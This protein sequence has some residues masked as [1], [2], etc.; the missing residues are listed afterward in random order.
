MSI[1]KSD[2]KILFSESGGVCAF[3]KCERR[4]VQ[5]E[6]PDDDAVLLA[7]VAH[8]VAE[9]SDGPRGESP[10]SLAERNKAGNL[11]VL[12]TEHHTIV[13]GQPNTYGVAVLHQMKLD[14]QHRIQRLTS[15][16]RPIAPPRHSSETLL[17]TLLPVTRLPAF[18]F[19]APCDLDDAQDKEVREA[20][21]YPENRW[22]IAPFLIRERTLFAF[23]SLCDPSNPFRGVVDYAKAESVPSKQFWSTPEGQRRFVTLLNRSLYKYTSRLH[24]RYDPSHRRYLFFPSEPGKTRSVPY[25]TGTNKRGRRKVVWRPVTKITGEPKNHW[26][27]LAAAL[28]FQRVAEEQWCLSIRPERHLTVDGE[29]PLASEKIGRRVTRLKAKM[30]NE[31]Y[32]SEIHF[33]RDYL[34]RGGRKRMTLNYG[35][36]HAMVDW[37]FLEF[38]V[39][40]PGI[41]GDSKPFSNQPAEDDLFDLFDELDPDWDASVNPDEDEDDDEEDTE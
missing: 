40:S 7:H 16:T 6:T 37:Q 18:V 3:P 31:P 25:R 27:H 14:H 41:P 39:I 10:L 35:A 19:S 20:L 2:L 24:V 30:Y 4:L 38:T 8:I 26:L 17:S 34:C 36:Q 28:R 13:D 33:W 5:A 11:L 15:P 22:E 32:L 9:S 1:S 12:C 21:K 23:H 29:T